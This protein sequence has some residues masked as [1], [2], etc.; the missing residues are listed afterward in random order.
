MFKFARGLIVCS[1]SKSY[2]YCNYNIYQV[3]PI[4]GTNPWP[5]VT[6]NSLPIDG[7]RVLLDVVA[8]YR[9]Y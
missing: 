5:S 8:Y 1:M 6:S 4:D 3:L 9:H 2:K 7:L